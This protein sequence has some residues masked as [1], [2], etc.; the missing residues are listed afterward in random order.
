MTTCIY[1]RYKVEVQQQ[2]KVLHFKPS[3]MLKKF[4]RNYG[5][6]EFRGIRS[7]VKFTEFRNL[8]P[9]SGVIPEEKKFCNIPLGTRYKDHC[10]PYIHNAKHKT[11]HL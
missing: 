3:A 8:I 5:F 4:Q 10:V 11:L 2:M 1:V 6:T 9:D 7:S